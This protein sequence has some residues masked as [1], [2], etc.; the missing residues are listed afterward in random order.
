MQEGLGME[1]T[2][3][4]LAQDGVG[5]DGVEGIVASLTFS[6]LQSEVPDSPEALLSV[7]APFIV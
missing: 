2:F 5:E 3:R 4:V 1:W 7:P 6:C